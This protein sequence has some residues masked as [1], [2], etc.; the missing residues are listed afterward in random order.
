[1]THDELA[2]DL[3]RH[4]RATSDAPMV[5]TDMQLGPVGS[6]RPDVYVMAKSYTGLRP[7]A[8]EVK[9]SVSDFRADV[10]A[11]KWQSYRAM[12]SGI[13]FAFPSTLK[14]SK[15]DVPAECGL[16]RR[17]METGKWRSIRRPILRP[18]D[19]LPVKVWQKLLID[20]VKR[21]KSVV[22]S[23]QTSLA[24][25][26]QYRAEDDARKRWG[27]VTADVI[28]SLSD[29]MA[30]RDSLVSELSTQR[31]RQDAANKVLVDTAVRRAT[32]AAQREHTEVSAR[33]RELARAIGL[34]YDC[35]VEDIRVRLASV[36]GILKAGDVSHL[37]ERLER[38][39]ATLREGAEAF[40][41]IRDA[42]TIPH[43]SR[44]D[45]VGIAANDPGDSVASL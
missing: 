11:G 13:W 12:A 34:G 26:N 32:D 20:G 1:M 6:P 33:E 2:E 18:L 36:I 45:P 35:S 4:I 25:F 23:A 38:Q 8:Y 19:N 44:L 43:K 10:T 41:S 31:D 5:W 29:A 42:F 28:R 27:K 37:A 14:I 7:I 40:E 17:D 24:G 21:E 39:A 16:I 22:S 9:V 15:D 3:A 30:R